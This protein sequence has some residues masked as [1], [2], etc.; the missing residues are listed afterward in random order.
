MFNNF[1]TNP[2]PR[3]TITRTPIYIIGSGNTWT[4]LLID[5]ATG[6]PTGSVFKPHPAPHLPGQ[7]HC[8]QRVRLYTCMLICR[9]LWGMG[10]YAVGLI[11]TFA[12]HKRERVQVS[13]VKAHPNNFRPEELL[14]VATT[15]EICTSLL[16]PFVYANMTEKEE[17]SDS[18]VTH[19]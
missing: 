8:H 16:V 18:V 2:F 13:V 4:R 7:G 17:R 3:T 9:G 15:G 1:F 12:A 11:R 5:F 19:A 10:G 14:T 6:V